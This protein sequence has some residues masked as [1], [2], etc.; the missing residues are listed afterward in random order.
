MAKI[1]GT[2]DRYEEQ[3][4]RQEQWAEDRKKGRLIIKKDEMKFELTKTGLSA[5]MIDAFQGFPTKS[6]NMFM[7]EINPGSHTGC[8]RHNCEAVI[9]ILKGKGYSVVNEQRIDWEEGDALLIPVLA[10]HQHFNADS[11]KPARYLA[12]S[13]FPQLENMGMA[14]MEQKEESPLYKK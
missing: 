5:Y 14:I 7:G 13:N 2:A 3:L 8:H 4:Q 12:T 11:T 1:T 10:W 6:L 9:Y